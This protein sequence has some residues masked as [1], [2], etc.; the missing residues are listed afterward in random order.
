MSDAASPAPPTSPVTQRSVTPA[1]VTSGQSGP[2]G[3]TPQQ[4]GGQAPPQQDAPVGR[5]AVTFSASLAGMKAGAR[6]DAV[7]I[8]HDA[9][10]VPV[11]RRGGGT[12]VATTREPLPA[13][14]QLTLEIQ[15]TGTEIKAVIVARNGQPLQPPTDIRLL[16]T[17]VSSQSP[18]TPQQ[19]PGA[20]AAGQPATVVSL[21][22]PS[23]GA[24][25][26]ALQLVELL[27]GAQ[28][29]G[30]AVAT[31]TTPSTAASGAPPAP[32]AAAAPASAGGASL[33]PGIPLLVRVTSLGATQ[34]PG[35][36]STASNL[37][38]GPAPQG[39]SAPP[40]A[41][42]T[43]G[44]SA[45]LPGPA[46]GATA[47][48]GGATTA[49]QQGTPVAPQG[50]TTA[51][52]GPA[53]GLAPAPA[54]TQQS[55][56]IQLSGVVV[57]QGPDGRAV[58]QTSAGTLVIDA[59]TTAQIGTSITVEVTRAGAA[60][61][62]AGPAAQA[63]AAASPQAA[64]IDIASGWTSLREIVQ[65]VQAIDPAIARQFIERRI[66]SLNARGA[67]NVLFFLAALRGGDVAGWLGRDMVR[68]L[69]RN[70]QRALIDRL[71]DDFGQLRRFVDPD[72]GSEWRTLVFPFYDGEAIHQASMFVR[73]RRARP[74]EDGEDD[75]RF[76][77]D[78]DLS[79]LGAMQL[80][81]LVRDKAFDLIVRS[82]RDLDQT[83]RQEIS[84]LFDGALGATGLTGS[85]VFQTSASFPITP[86]Q[87]IVS[88]GGGTVVA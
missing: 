10:G 49:G 84:Q 79:A 39:S 8:G 38:P 22:A 32:G 4:S 31:S 61:A 53:A 74:G 65:L 30:R 16:L 37:P 71:A 20:P 6:V 51:G 80:D 29:L 15:S 21:A 25:G 48:S 83:M 70:G 64:L 46:G 59:R 11:V 23:A 42:A 14:T 66:P 1:P 76:V 41:G 19:G 77:V 35:S 56:V 2:Q 27:P 75:L 86:M 72:G 7:V 88:S 54:S 57:G 5:P 17:N 24:A 45:T 78:L 81:G 67:S 44:S 26:T 18:A 12:F 47:P 73:G 28:V 40:G 9:E 50:S 68:V 85:L 36:G 62:Q 69:E 34:Q 3:E 55:P 82:Q 58:L 43:P 63:A 33:V 87:D 52:A 60:P 13:N